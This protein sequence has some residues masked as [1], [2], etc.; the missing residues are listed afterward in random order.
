MEDFV[1]HKVLVLYVGG[2]IGMQKNEEGGKKFL[3]LKKSAYIFYFI[4]SMIL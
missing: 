4:A 3:F 1:V 2:T